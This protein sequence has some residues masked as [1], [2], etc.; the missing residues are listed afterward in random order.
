METLI[1]S[2]AVFVHSMTLLYGL[3]IL[4]HY[5]VEFSNRPDLLSAGIDD[6]ELCYYTVVLSSLTTPVTLYH[7]FKNADITI[8]GAG[9]WLALG[10]LL[11]LFHFITSK[12]MNTVRSN[13][14]HS[15]FA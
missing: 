6:V 11:L 10:L 3:V 1:A 15:S 8:Y 2:L 12:L 7:L 13:G 14:T 4:N 5:S 9:Y